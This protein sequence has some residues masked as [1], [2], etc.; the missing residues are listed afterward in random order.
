MTYRHSR[1]GH[2]LRAGRRQRRALSGAP[3]LLRRPQLRRAREGDG[4]RRDEGAAVLLHQARRCGRAGR[5][6][7]GR[8]HRAIRSRRRTSITRSSSSSRSA[9]RGV[10]AS[11]PS[12]RSTL[13]FGYAV[14]LDMTRR[15]LQNDMREKKRPWDIGKSFAQAAPIAPI[16]PVAAVGHPA[17]GAIWLDVNGA[18]RQQGDL[19][20][21][22]WDVAAHARVPVAVLRAPARRPRLHRHA[23]GRRRR[24]RRRPARRR[25]ST[26]SARCR[27]RSRRRSRE[28]A[29][30]HR[31]T[32]EFVERGYNNRAAVPDHPQWFARYARASAAARARFAP[33]L[34][35]RYGPGPKETLDLFV[36][37]GP[38]RAATFVFIHGG[39]WRALDKSDFSFVAAPF[40]AQGIAVAVVNYDLCPDGVDRDDRRR[41]P[42]RGRVARRAKARR[43]APTRARRRR[44]A[45]GGRPSRRDDVRDRLG[46][47]TGSR[48]T[49]IRRRRVAVGRARP[50]AAGACSR[51]TPTSSSTTPRRRGC[52]PSR[53]RAA[54]GGAAA[55]RGAAPTR[56]P[57]SCARRRSCGTRGRRTGRPA[58]AAPLFVPARNHFS[59]VADYADPG[60][61]ARRAGRSALF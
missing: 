51:S 18:R 56:R 24:R 22:I 3:H 52:R 47:R 49:P 55:D 42:A 57:S 11:R 27:S 34:D 16:H 41:M 21:M 40:V 4:R 17:R 5:A 26:A 9:A 14:G 12:A 23:V 60:E 59:V 32:P 31:Y 25:A 38:R 48:A 37:A 19:A 53:L 36:P 39:Y 28:R 58:I 33:Q 54:I 50:R 43:T 7:G 1:L 45:F 15:D 35:L 30:R 29:W 2:S 13:V 8:P 46:A 44:R 10:E 61:R 6:A 20:D